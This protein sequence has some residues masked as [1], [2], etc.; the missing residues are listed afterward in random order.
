MSIEPSNSIIYD[1]ISKEDFK[2]FLDVLEKKDPEAYKEEGIDGFSDLY[3]YWSD[4][5]DRRMKTKLSQNK[6]ALGL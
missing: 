3:N 5:G 4:A 6:E 2:E 1:I